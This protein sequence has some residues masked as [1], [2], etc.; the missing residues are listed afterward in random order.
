[1]YTYNNYVAFHSACLQLHNDA[2]NS[3]LNAITRR[4]STPRVKYS[5]DA[6]LGQKRYLYLN[7]LFIQNPYTNI[8]I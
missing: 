3:N 6:L 7:F 2:S 4:G 1:M 5:V 8:Y